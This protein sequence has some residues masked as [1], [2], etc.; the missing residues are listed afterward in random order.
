[1]KQYINIY[2]VCCNTDI[3]TTN[4]D[5]KIK[6]FQE[7]IENIANSFD[8]LTSLTTSIDGQ[9]LIFENQI[10]VLE[11]ERDK[12]IRRAKSLRGLV[13][14]R[15]DSLSVHKKECMDMM[16]KPTPIE[17]NEKESFAHLLIRLVSISGTFKTGCDTYLEL[18]EKDYLE[19]LKFIKLW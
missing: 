13:S 8:G 7:K 10:Y 16:G 5:K 14:P 9:N 11:K 19:I 4:V 3:L 6:E 12:I 15:L 1:M 17:V 18:Q 2:K